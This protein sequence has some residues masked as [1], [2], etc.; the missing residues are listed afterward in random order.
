MPLPL[1]IT[2]KSLEHVFFRW[3]WPLSD[4]SMM[5][6]PMGPKRSFRS[7]IGEMWKSELKNV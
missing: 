3:Q 5:R 2:F 1:V 7:A 4:S 6:M